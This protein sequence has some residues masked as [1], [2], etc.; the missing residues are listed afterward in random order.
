MTDRISTVVLG[1]TGYVAGELLRLAT[2]HPGLDVTAVVSES[3]AGT[4]IGDTFG[5]LR[6]PVAAL[7]YISR[8]ELSPHLRG[9]V[10]IFSAAPH[11]A[12]ASLVRSV[13]DEGAATGADISL[14]DASADFRFGDLSRYETVYG[15]PH[16]APAL[17]A[18]FARGLP[19]H[20]DGTPGPHVGHPGCFATAMLLGMVPMLA[21][22][23]VEPHI[24]AT[25]VTGSTGSGKSPTATTHHPVRHSNMFAYKPLAH[26]HAPEVTHLAAAAT[27]IEPVLSFVP[28]SGPFAR[29]IHMT[30]QARGA[31]TA[32]AD[33][34]RDAFSTFYAGQPFVRIIDGT[35]RI[36]DVA[37]SNHAD[38]GVACEGGTVAVFVTIDNLVKGAAGGAMQWMNRLLGHDETAGLMG[39]APGWI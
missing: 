38:I 36:K 26:R 15:Q 24:F 3:R 7:P 11:G 21:N 34:V 37:G 2:A 10:A 30:L 20:V 19:E 17:N 6:G 12:S 1:G 5:H 9:R 33:T 39:H 35:P 28:H 31:G 22:G 18:E 29:G 23:L 32:D 25:G 13:L 27:G 8:D 14:V 16:G 4:P